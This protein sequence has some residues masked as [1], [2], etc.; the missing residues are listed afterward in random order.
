MGGGG[1]LKYTS[2]LMTSEGYEHFL[3]FI[4]SW[5]EITADKMDG[6][7]KNLTVFMTV[8][9]WLN[10]QGIFGKSRDHCSTGLDSFEK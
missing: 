2:C 4:Y 8:K 1:E 3:K 5:L 6:D 7:L 9:L 10:Y